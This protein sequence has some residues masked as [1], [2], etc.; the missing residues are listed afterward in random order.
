MV[1]TVDG[2]VKGISP[3]LGEI[4]LD[5]IGGRGW[6]LPRGDLVLPVLALR[7]SR[8][9]QNLKFLKRYAEEHGV[10]LAPHGKTPMAPEL[11]REILSEGGAWGISV[12]TVQQAAVA[13]G[14]GAGKVLIPNQVLGPANIAGLAAL[15][16]AYPR[17]LFACFVDSVAALQQLV[18]HGRD[19]LNKGD[20]FDILIEV[21]AEGAR[22][23]ARTSAQVEAV[24]AAAK[25]AADTVRIVGVGCYEGAIARPDPGDNLRAVDA[26]LSFA[27]DTFN[28]AARAGV[29]AGLPEAILTG[30]GSSWF[31]RVTVA[32][33]E[34]KL[35]HPARLVLRCGSYAFID[36]RLYLEKLAAMEARGGISA[37]GETL[38]PALELWAVVQ[39]TQDP[40]RA[41]VAM[42]KRD[43]P[44]DAGYPIP[45]R[46]YRDGK[47][48]ARLGKEGEEGACR[49]LKSDDQHAYLAYPEGTDVQV[50]D[51]IAFG[52]SHPCTAFDKW[53]LVFR[54][55]EDFNVTGAVATEF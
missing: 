30:G 12:A 8:F 10:C 19:R 15:R 34:A 38:V 41:I 11:F 26:Y 54:V 9:R 48:L 47:L 17:R 13:A 49:I 18:R 4:A 3:A 7:D 53:R 46:Q 23:G 27:V 28:R 21:G 31:D 22:T 5:S 43:L 14:A 40:G 35:E 52:I 51:I 44:Y 20:R 33:T 37:S 45:M 1:Q 32:F 42:G 55:D 25:Q 2:R 39:S 36:H 50:G 16:S 6:N 29:F 24:V